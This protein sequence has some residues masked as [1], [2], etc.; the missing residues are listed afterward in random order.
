MIRKAVENAPSPSQKS[1]VNEYFNKFSEEFFTTLR[2]EL[3]RVNDFFDYKLAEA[4][5]KHATFKVKL[6]YIFRSAGGHMGDALTSA[7]GGS[8]EECS[9]SGKGIQRVLL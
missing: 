6:M 3:R 8:T 2:E 9:K 4:R 1:Q 5:R 7:P